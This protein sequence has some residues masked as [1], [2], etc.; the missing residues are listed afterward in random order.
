MMWLKALIVSALLIVATSALAGRSTP[1]MPLVVDG[2]RY[3]RVQWEAGE[4]AQRPEVHGHILNEFGFPARKVRLLVNSLDPAGAVTDQTLVY[5]PGELL[6]G[7][8][9]YFETPVPA[10]ATSYRVVVF[11]FEWIQAGG[12]DSRR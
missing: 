6:P 8:R 12:G 5:V 4:R 7:S 3:F 10:P 1:L 2:E 11:Q 9:Y